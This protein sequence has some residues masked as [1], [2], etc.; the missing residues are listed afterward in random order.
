MTHTHRAT[1]SRTP[2]GIRDHATHA[3][4][5]TASKHVRVL[6]GDVVASSTSLILD[7]VLGSCVAVCLHDPLLEIGGMNHIL[8]PGSS[9][10]QTCSRY[11][12]HAMEL[13]INELMKLGADRR[14]LLAKAFGGVNVL[15][16]LKTTRIGDINVRFVRQF[17]ETE[18]IQLIAAK[19]GGK[20]AMH[21]LF[22]TD[23]GKA[24]VRTVGDDRLPSIAHDETAYLRVHATDEYTSGDVT[25]F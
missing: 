24:I 18:G 19:F 16:D 17:L 7:A 20:Q 4:R 5:E 3:P 13:L 12:V 15:A 23:S 25:L 11:G 6:T 2:H 8:L 9:T 10:D 1:G 14:R 21:V 22:R